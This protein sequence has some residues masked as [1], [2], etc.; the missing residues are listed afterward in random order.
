M[1]LYKYVPPERLDILKNLRVR[2]TQPGAQNDPFEF[3][4]LVR[5]FRQPEKSGRALAAQ[6]DQEFDRKLD[7]TLKEFIRRFPA[8]VASIREL[9]LVKADALAEKAAREEIFQELN[10][11]VGIL[12]LS[13]VPD[14]FLMWWRYASG[15]SG[16]VYEFDDKHPWF[17]AKSEDKDDTH[18]LRK[19]TYVD[20]PSSP[21]LTELSALEVLYSKRMVWA[22]EKEW[23]IIRPL[24]ESSQRI[25]EDVHLFAMPPAALTGIVVGSAANGESFRELARVL[26]G[27]PELA[28]LRIGCAHHVPSEQAVHIEFWPGS[29]AQIRAEFAAALN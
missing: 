28:H 26:A 25:G 2:F 18:E 14:S 23:R 11:R 6:Y 4:P 10:Q 29:V 22:Y 17:W 21:Y 24:V 8:C 13:E 16:F 19:V 7:P 3:Q 12:S 5:R 1:S 15:L 27:N 9:G 20:L